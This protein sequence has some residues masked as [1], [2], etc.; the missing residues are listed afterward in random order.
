M[1]STAAG[2]DSD[3]LANVSVR[4][5]QLDWPEAGRSFL[6]DSTYK[7]SLLKDASITKSADFGNP[8]AIQDGQVMRVNGFDLYP[9]PRI[10]VNGQALKGFAVFRSAIIVATAA[11]QPTEDVRGQL[12]GYEIIVE[13]E[14][15]IAIAHRRWG[16][17]DM[18]S[19]RETVECSYGYAV[20]ES[21][22][23]I[24]LTET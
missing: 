18:D 13:P 9:N 5:D 8:N 2:F 3:D 7:G 20:G 19:T 23:L 11:V 16:N 17:P 1:T 15:G 21:K 4:C 14:T 12:S 22:A 6:M 24:R 10:P